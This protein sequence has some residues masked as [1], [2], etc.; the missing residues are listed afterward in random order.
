MAPAIPQMDLE[1]I[2]LSE[3]SQEEVKDKY[4]MISL[5]C[6]I[7]KNKQTNKQTGA[8]IQRTD[9][10]MSEMGMGKLGRGSQKVQISSY[11]IC[12]S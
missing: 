5:I 8:Q 11:K 6:G 4:Y 7:S 12:K 10:W 1:D 3:T 9:W 2:V